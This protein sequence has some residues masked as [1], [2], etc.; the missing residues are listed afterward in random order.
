M[1]STAL[2]TSI[3]LVGG[4]LGAFASGADQVGRDD[5]P[6][7]VG[8]VDFIAV[9]RTGQPIADLRADEVTLRVG[10]R[11]R[12]VRALQFIQVSSAMRG[13]A[14]GLASPLESIA[15]PF[16]SNMSTVAD[17]PRSFVIVV[18]DESMPIGEERRLR[19]ALNNFVRDLPEFDYVALV[20][21]PHGGL[22]VGL[23]TD[24]DL[25]RREIANI[26]PMTSLAAPTC[27]TRS[28]LAALETT[29]NRIVRVSQQPVIVAFL[30]ASLMGQSRMEQAPVP[31]RGALSAQAGSCFLH[32]DDFAR[33]GKTLAA[34]RGQLYVIN[35]DFSQAPV[36][37]GIEHLQGQTGAPLFHL[38]AGTEPGLYRMARE[39]SA[40]YIVTFATDPEE[41]DGQAQPA[42]IR[43]TRRDVEVR[44]R[45]Y[46][47]LPRP[48][49]IPA[50]S[51]TITTAFDM[52]RNGRQYRDLPIRATT[53]SFRNADGSVNVVG[54]FE[55]ID[56][57]SRIMTAAA[58]L[59]NEN[60]RAVA[61]WEGEAD[62]MSAW[63]TAIGLTV[64]P[65][66][67]RLRIAAIDSNGRLGLVDD[68]FEAEIRKAGPIQVSGLS[69]GVP[70]GAGFAPRLQFSADTS[71]VAYL[72]MYGLLS[73]MEA[74]A[75]FEVSTTT[76]GPALMTLK[77][78]F[79]A[80]SV[81]GR[82]GVTATIPLSTLEPGNYVV[83]AIVAAAGQPAVRAIRTLHKAR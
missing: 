2:V 7:Q 30:S 5:R 8:S 66:A 24:R 19:T 81:E 79:T 39:T 64:P 68:K 13:A 60:G 25:L 73:G 78:A 72:E 77:G 26:S 53:T 33:V 23:T 49:P 18:D 29:L 52:V 83:R 9:T 1:R 67:Y 21:V 17:A 36:L 63:P 43:I 70:D 37:E 4:A 82:F 62:K 6:G 80:T 71:A 45:P 59:I 12:P 40:Y 38:G 51:T 50:A 27:R 57:S 48:A 58:A 75:V 35:P 32:T 76:N 11:I 74:G 47:V 56:P 44:G 20:T 28:T 15:P 34:N 14:P 42:S 41:R 55:P 46:V 3:A 22:R 54:W 31:A 61:Y 65:G 69:L 10:N 16:A